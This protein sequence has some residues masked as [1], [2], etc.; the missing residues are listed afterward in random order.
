MQKTKFL[1]QSF[2]TV[3]AVVLIFASLSVGSFF[4]ASAATQRGVITSGKNDYYSA[5]RQ[6]C[7]RL[8]QGIKNFDE[9]L[10]KN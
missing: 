2:S 3:L 5:N 6:V 10:M 9:N 7:D 8:A 4:S 1:K